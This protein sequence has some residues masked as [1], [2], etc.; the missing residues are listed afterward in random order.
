MNVIAAWAEFVGLGLKGLGLSEESRRV[1]VR[2]IAKD[3]G[4]DF[5]KACAIL[6]AMTAAI[7]KSDVP[8]RGTE[9]RQEAK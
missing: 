3:S 5:E 1:L 2:E 8:F 6:E 7:G 4:Y 9:T